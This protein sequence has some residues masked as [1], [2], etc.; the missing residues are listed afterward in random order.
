M[1]QDKTIKNIF[2]G[3][4]DHVSL[5]LELLEIYWESVIGYFQFF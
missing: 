5:A 2:F 1:L 3:F 4:Q